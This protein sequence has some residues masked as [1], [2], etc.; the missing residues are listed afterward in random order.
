MISNFTLKFG[1]TPGAPAQEIAPTPVT[2]F[3]GPNNSG[4]SR[5][6][7]EI[8]RYCRS[9]IKDANA[10]VLDDITFSGLDLENTQKAI[11]QIRQLPDRGEVQA[12][13]HIIV[14][15]QAGRNQVQLAALLQVIQRPTANLQVFCAYFLTHYTLM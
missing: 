2:V 7:V 1:R 3:V 15:S 13:D 6:L 9:G 12:E 11:D 10:I 8:E 14:E 4:K 5:A